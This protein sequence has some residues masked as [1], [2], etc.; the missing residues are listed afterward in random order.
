MVLRLPLLL[1]ALAVA[2]PAPA[3]ER[4]PIAVARVPLD[5]SGA[6]RLRLSHAPLGLRAPGDTPLPLF[7]DANRI[8]GDGSVVIA[9]GDVEVRRLG[10]RIAA[11]RMSYSSGDDALEASGGVEMETDLA[12]LHGTR[13]GYRPTGQ[14]G[15][16]EDLDYVIKP[17]TAAAGGTRFSRG[18]HGKAEALV[19]AGEDQYRL[20]GATFST[21]S[22]DDDSWFMRVSD[23]RLDYGTETGYGYN[24]AV[25]FKGVPIFYSPWITFP[26]NNKRRTGFLPPTFG[27]T[28][29]S[30]FELTVPY[31][32]NLA[33]NMDAT[34]APRYFAKRGNQINT[35]FRYLGH[36]LGG[37]TRL[38]YL[39]DDRL[40]DVD[41]WA[42]GL[43]HRQQ[44][45]LGLSASVS[46][47]GVSDDNYY[48][49]LST[50]ASSSAQTQLAR[51]GA[52]GWGGGGWQAG[53]QVLRYQTLQPDPANPVARPYELMPQLNVAGR[54][55]LGGDFSGLLAA[56]YTDFAHPDPGRLEAQRSVLYPQLALHALRPWGYL[57]PKLGLHMTRYIFRGDGAVGLPQEEY[58]RAV[59]I[60]SIDSGLVF[61]RR[62]NWFGEDT[63][64]TLEPRLYY[65]Y[66]PLRDQAFLT[67]NN[68]NF[69]SGIADFNFAQI[70]S[71]NLFTGQDRIA[72]AN[73]LTVAASSR[74]ID[75]E[76][77]SE[78]LNITLGQRFYFAPQTVT[79]NPGES[80]R[81]ERKTDILGAATGRIAET[82]WVDGGMQYNPRDG[83]MERSF[84]STRYLPRPGHAL[85]AAYRMV[86]EQTAP[87]DV[88]VEQVDIAGQWPLF[89]GWQG[90]GR[91]NYA[92][93][94]KRPIEIV[95]GLEYH[96]ACWSARAVMQRYATTATETVSAVFFQL[97]LT[98]FSRI[99]SSPLELL[100]RSVPGYGRVDQSVSDPVFGTP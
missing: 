73:Q 44:L 38:E 56:Q 72:D 80:R 29:V 68:I 1:S 35:E 4:E 31:Y 89:G 15:R 40:R 11:E 93:D 5:D 63:I 84:I 41:R 90:V 8:I 34:L 20:D 51:Q 52:L 3:A 54:E 47:S 17:Q 97:E 64:Q 6:P 81:T 67:A 95:A 77:G 48:R 33:P 76:S 58:D 24:A 75:P 71:E 10:L 50:R 88:S 60:A 65:L 91:Y 25:W 42:Y 45:P 86:R 14:T 22:A 16:L 27:S 57:T 87:F 46:A 66:V 49:D 2:L 100:R 99:G 28:S 61:E 32:L 13:L 70:F 9:S 83:R 94:E 98:D 7:I 59:P 92:L 36:T 53:L 18:A 74:F 12:V 96:A 85:S 21:C 30:G 78:R 19:F 23:L 62:A 37:E 55:P 26:L 79:L 43:Q 82:V 69:D 39:P